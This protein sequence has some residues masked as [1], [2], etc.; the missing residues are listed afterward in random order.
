MK[1]EIEKKNVLVKIIGIKKFCFFFVM[2]GHLKSEGLNPRTQPPSQKSPP[3]PL[4]K[5]NSLSTLK[6]PGKRRWA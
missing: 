3:P 4:T 2:G 1:I 5:N 6:I